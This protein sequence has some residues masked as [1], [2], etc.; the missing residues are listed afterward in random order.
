MSPAQ[1]A[2]A[3]E[4]ARLA[5][6][7]VDL[8]ATRVPRAIA[9]VAALRRMIAEGRDPTEAEWSALLADGEALHARIQAAARE[10]D[11]A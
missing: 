2:A 5:I 4:G 6:Q 7:L 1:L 11:G 9:G 3:M 10:D 8:A